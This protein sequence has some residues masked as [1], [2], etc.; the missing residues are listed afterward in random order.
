MCEAGAAAILAGAP[1]KKKKKKQK[2]NTFPL[3]F[4]CQYAAGFSCEDIRFFSFLEQLPRS[5]LAELF[6]SIFFLPQDI[7]LNSKPEGKKREQK[8]NFLFG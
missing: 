1:Y 2:K 7:S 5:E 4:F 6:H 8:G 3:D